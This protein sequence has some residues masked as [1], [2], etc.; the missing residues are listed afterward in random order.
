MMISNA[1]LLISNTGLSAAK[2][3]M[4]VMVH[5][6]S[7]LIGDAQVWSSFFCS[8]EVIMLQLSK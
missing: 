4:T 6:L 7:T 3:K 8:E 2:I 1:M 5:L